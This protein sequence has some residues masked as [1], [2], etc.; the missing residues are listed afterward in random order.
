MKLTLDTKTFA[1]TL[2]WIT[3]NL[4]SHPPMPVM[5]GVKLTAT[6]DTVQAVGRDWE[7]TSRAVL[8]ADVAQDGTVLLPGRL[9]ADITRQL[10]AG[11][12]QIVV[13]DA[14]CI[15]TGP[16]STFTLQTLPLDDYPDPPQPPDEAGRMSAEAFT[17][18]ITQ[19]AIAAGHDSTVPMLTGLRMEFTGDQIAFAA[20]DR[21]RLAA[22]ART[23]EPAGSTDDT[24]D[25]GEYALVAPAATLANLAKGIDRSIEHITLAISRHATDNGTVVTGL[26]ITA[27]TRTL[28][29]RVLEDNFVKWRKILPATFTAS[30]LADTGELA[31]AVRR[32]ATVAERNT[33]VRLT[34]TPGGGDAEGEIELQAG[35]G[36][37]AA[38]RETLP[39]LVTAT[40]PLTIAF[41]PDYLLDALITVPGERMCL[42]TTDSVKPAVMVPA[43]ADTGVETLPASGA[44]GPGEHRHLLM[45]VRVTS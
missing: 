4:P 2:S 31:A 6:A 40:K 9:L 14:T 23:W 35:H 3:R 38:A 1:D 16:R 7:V 13:E 12:L 18:A 33:P 37:A 32:V 24:D 29:T 26:S 21:Y 27:G 20:T 43:P 11:P 15:L 36:D 5:A 34:C 17:S 25:S 44:P 41:N 28:H 8:D 19:T 42:H 10:P 39:A 22:A 45:P 30:T